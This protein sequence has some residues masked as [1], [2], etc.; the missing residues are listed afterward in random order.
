MSRNWGHEWIST[1]EYLGIGFL[2]VV[3]VGAV[4]AATLV[5]TSDLGRHFWVVNHRFFLRQ[6]G[7]DAI[8]VWASMVGLTLFLLGSVR[9]DYL[10]TYQGNDL[11]TACTDVAEAIKGHDVAGLHAGESMFW[12]SIKIFAII[13]TFHVLRLSAASYVWYRFECRWRSWL[14]DYLVGDWLGGAAAYRMRFLRDP[15]D[16]PDQRVDIDVTD[17]V[18]NSQTLIGGAVNA[19]VSAIVF[20]QLLWD[21]CASVPIFG[22]AVPRALIAVAIAYYIVS[23]I[24]TFLIGRRMIRWN[25]R[26]QRST[27]RFRAR[28]VHA[29]TA[30]EEIA[31]FRGAFTEKQTL[32]GVFTSVIRAFWRVSILRVAV[33]SWGLAIDQA[34]VL[35]PYLI[36]ASRFFHGQI[37][38]GTLTQSA[39]SFTSF[40]TALSF[41]QDNYPTY[42]EYRAQLIRLR[43]L[44]VGDREAREL[45][46]PVAGEPP[47]GVGVRLAGAGIDKPDGTPLLRDVTV[48]VRSGEALLIRGPS[49]VGK[50]TLLRALSGL[51]PYT[52]GTFDAVDPYVVTQTPYLPFASLQEVLAYPNAAETVS[53]GA[54]RQVLSIVGLDTLDLYA[55]ITDWGFLSPGEQQ[56]LVF[57]RML[58][59]R[60]AVILLDEATSAVDLATEARLYGLLR[61]RLPGSAIVSVGHRESLTGFHDR[62][63]DLS[64]APGRFSASVE[65]LE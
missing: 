4:I 20:G 62:V 18:E 59:A 27:G 58:L 9:V 24:V 32:T 23:T 47:T 29:R 38:F 52:H 13:V 26:Y 36:Q 14:T 6:R 31:L 50:S 33:Q 44:I 54:A 40:Q 16:N 55:D 11:I 49:G 53:D 57:A 56:R 5:A 22:V 34:A 7:R 21:L 43:G 42:A 65:V 17:M 48:D 8:A 39:N 30:A 2:A 12:E 1:L 25:F 41:F 3:V 64:P 61:D 60:P 35:L 45:D 19:V 15:V 63:L 46:I 51:W 28:L 10:L 37:S